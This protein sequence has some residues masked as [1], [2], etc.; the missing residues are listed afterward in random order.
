L[1]QVPAFRHGTLTLWESHAIMVYMCNLV[2]PKQ[3]WYPNDLS[4]QALVNVY[5]HAHHQTTRQGLAGWFRRAILFAGR[6]SPEVVEKSLKE[7]ERQCNFFEQYWLKTGPFIMGF[8][9][10]TIA[11]LS[12]HQEFV[13]CIPFLNPTLLDPYPKLRKWIEAMDNL[14]GMQDINS[15]WLKKAVPALRSKI[16]AKL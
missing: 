13:Q 15:L 10:P 16:P 6:S 11:D 8:K 14:S 5:L 7:L 3:H 2:G 9:R 4:K 12:A 1:G